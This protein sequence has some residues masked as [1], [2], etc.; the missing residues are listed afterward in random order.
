MTIDEVLRF[1]VSLEIGRCGFLEMN[2]VAR[3]LSVLAVTGSSQDRRQTSLEIP[4]TRD[5]G[6]QTE[7]VTPLY[8][9]G[10]ITGDTRTLCGIGI[11][12]SVTTVT[13]RLV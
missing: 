10:T 2:C 11:V 12:T 9:C 7:N 4:Q 6:S 8:P 1:A 5:G 13:S 3:S